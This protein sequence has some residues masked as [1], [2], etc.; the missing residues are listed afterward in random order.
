MVKVRVPATSANLGPGFDVLGVAISMYNYFTVEE[1]DSGVEIEILPD[2]NGKLNLTERN[3]VYRSAIR[4][5]DEIGRKPTGLRIV[6]EIGVP[7]GRGLGSSSTAIVGGLTAANEICGNLLSKTDI[8]R[9]ATEIEGHPDN[10]APAIFGGFTVCYKTEDGFR[11][12]TQAPASNIKP[13]MLV[14]D[15]TLET[16]KAR[17]VLPSMINIED[18]VF[19]ISRTGLL[20]SSIMGG[21]TEY[22]KEAMSDKLHQPFRAPLIPGLVEMVREVGRIQ[23]TG[24]AL[25]GAGPSIICLIERDKEKQ[26]TESIYSVIKQN[27]FGYM[28]HAVEFDLSGA[29]VDDRSAGGTEKCCTSF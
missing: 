21:K 11:A 4:L 23:N 9:L 8:F 22:L 29:L 6:I 12:I 27:G 15:T 18:A 20:V 13:L 17:G 25:S 10:V 19:N 24:I 5:F 3:L 28:V 7:V 26:I 14:P 1:T 16:K 2:N